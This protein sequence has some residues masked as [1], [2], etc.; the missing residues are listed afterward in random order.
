MD[1]HDRLVGAIYRAVLEPDTWPQVIAGICSEVGGAAG[2][3]ALHYPSQVRSVYQIEFGT[4]P[5]R[6]RA[7]REHYVAA[8]PFIGIT[9]HVALGD[10]VSVGDVI[11]YEEFTEGRFFRE[12]A[13]PQGW[14]DFI[15]AV[16]ALEADRFSWLGI[17]LRERATAE[18][19]RQIALL[20]P[21]VERALRISDLLEIKSAEAADLAAAVAGLA[22]GLVLVD[23][24]LGVRGLNPA[25]ERLLGHAGWPAFAAGRLR[26]PKSAAGAELRDAVASCADGRL[27]RAGASILFDGEDEGLGL[28]VHVLPLSRPLTAPESKAVAALFLTDPLATERA[29]MDHFVKAYALT[30]SETRVLLALLEGKSPRAIATSQGVSMP[31]VRTHLHR[32]FDKTGTS[33]QT[34]LVRLAAGVSRPI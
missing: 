12:W 20:R 32:L 21:H 14:N 28:L 5:D 10:I 7:L 27:D 11:D 2:W 3:I 9:H 15:L 6:Q 1:R 26:P 29:P 18:Q 17:C 34:D 16:T 24:D 23:A 4:D 30:P 8:S 19:K 13:R 25:A 31:T 33:G 22:T